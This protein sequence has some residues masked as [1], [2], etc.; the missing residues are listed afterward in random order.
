MTKSRA[1]KSSSNCCRSYIEMNPILA[2]FLAARIGYLR[3]AEIAKESM[4]KKVSIRE[5][6]IAKDIIT[7]EE[8]EELF[9]PK[10]IGHK[11]SQFFKP[12]GNR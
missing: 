4:E 6:A 9:D 12:M 8:A 11:A 3:V 7:R 10:N 5:I 2:T 1:R